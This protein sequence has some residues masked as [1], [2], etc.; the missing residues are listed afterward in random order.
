MRDRFQGSTITVAIAVAAIGAVISVSITRTSAQ[1][2]AA[3]V[4]APTAACDN[5][6]AT[7]ASM[8]ATLESFHE[9]CRDQEEEHLDR[10]RQWFAALAPGLVRRDVGHRHCLVL[11]G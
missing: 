2:P 10:L 1:A 6:R 7:D 3:S 4:S 11:P 5:G 8:T 9:T